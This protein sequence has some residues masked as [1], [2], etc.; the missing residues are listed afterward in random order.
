MREQYEKDY[1]DFTLTDY[2]RDEL[3]GSLSPFTFICVVAVLTLF[4]LIMAY[5]ASYDASIREGYSHYHYL[6]EMVTYGIIALVSGVILF[7]MPR[8]KLERV[9]YFALPLSFLLLIINLI[10]KIDMD[11]VSLLSGFPDLNGSDAVMFSSVLALSFILPRIRDKERRGWFYILILILSLIISLMMMLS[12]NFCYSILFFLT[13]AVA[14]KSGKMGSRYI[15]FFCLFNVTLLCFMF[16]SSSEYLN[17]FFSCLMPYYFDTPDAHNASN[18]L[19]AIAE[20]GIFGKGIG[21]SYY[22][23]GLIDGIENEYIYASIAEETGFIGTL[24][25]ILFLFLFLFL[26]IRCAHRSKKTGDEFINISSLSFSFM[27]VFKALLS[28]LAVASVIPSYGISMPFF[29]ADGF[30]YFLTI[31]ECAILYRFMHITGRGYEKAR[32]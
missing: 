9:F 21:S 19:S 2:S 28:M 18:C 8:H 7:F 16:L 25:I 6:L 5:S 20:G 1:D 10:A 12:D 3:S 30:S 26:A 32:D 14:L 17:A 15:F 27:I 24:F 4:G 29:S 22:K 13:M 23:L 31:V 11:G